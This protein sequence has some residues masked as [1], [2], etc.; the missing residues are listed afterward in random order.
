MSVTI[1][2]TF[3]PEPV[4]TPEPE[5]PTVPRSARL[6][7]LA[8]VLDEM[9]RDGRVASYAEI[10]R[11]AGVSRARLSQITAL[12]GLAPDIQE[13]LL[14]GTIVVG[15]RSLREVLRSLSW[16]NHRR[17]ISGYHIS[18]AAQGATHVDSR[19]SAR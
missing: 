7:A 12:L 3:R 16:R 8:L 2:A 18:K 11:V 14:D 4:P 13:G 15:E 5:V 9:V 17:E 10:A 6:M 19:K 1:R